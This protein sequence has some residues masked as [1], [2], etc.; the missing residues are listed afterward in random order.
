VSA[1]FTAH[2][3]QVLFDGQHY[4]DAIDNEAAKAI[5]Y[6]MNRII[7]D[8]PATPSRPDTEARAA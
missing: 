8:V 6:A 4:A 3:K 1:R 5:A 2:G 7:P